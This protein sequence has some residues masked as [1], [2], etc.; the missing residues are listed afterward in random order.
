MIWLFI[1]RPMYIIYVCYA[2]LVH[3]NVMMDD[4]IKIM[5]LN[6]M[7]TRV[8]SKLFSDSR[9]RRVYGVCWKWRTLSRLLCFPS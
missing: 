4:V 5:L 6:T 2:W 8:C 9:R 1:M 3:A 7:N